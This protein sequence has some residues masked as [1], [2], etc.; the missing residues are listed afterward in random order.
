MTSPI[1]HL[2]CGPIGAGKTNYSNTLAES[3]KG[4]RFSIDEWMAALFAADVPA[5]MEL[6]WVMERVER[7]QLQ[8]L[9]TALQ[10]SSRGTDVVLDLGFTT[11]RHRMA[12]TELVTNAGY[13]GQLHYLDVS[14][15]ERWGRVERRNA[16]RS[17][18]YSFEISRTMFDYMEARFE[19]PDEAHLLARSHLA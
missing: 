5:P 6:A 1:F 18:G 17:N 11:K 2:V 9:A 12:T 15:E 14:V 3:V 13:S 16:S 7:C 4:V 19:V 8:I 10:V